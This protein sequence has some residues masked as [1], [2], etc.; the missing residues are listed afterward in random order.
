MVSNWWF[1]MPLKPIAPFAFHLIIST[2]AELQFGTE[3]TSCSF[4]PSFYGLAPSS[5]TKITIHFDSLMPMTSCTT[6]TVLKGRCSMYRNGLCSSFMM[7]KSRFLLQEKCMNVVVFIDGIVT[8]SLT[9][10]TALSWPR[11]CS[12]ILTYPNCWFFGNFPSRSSL[13]AWDADPRPILLRM[14]EW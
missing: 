4:F 8:C 11:T 6:T 9:S 12:V 7:V 13:R 5:K 2:N 10:G 1:T 14:S 3:S